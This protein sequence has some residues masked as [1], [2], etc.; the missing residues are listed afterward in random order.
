[1]ASLLPET[2]GRGRSRFSKALP[3]APREDSPERLIKPQYSP[4]PP[5]PKDAMPAPITIPRRPVGS[6]V[7]E[8]LGRPKAPSV[9]TT[10]SSVYSASTGL[11]E[12]S[13]TSSDERDSLSGVDSEETGPPP[14]LPKKDVQRRGLAG[15]PK[16]PPQT[17]VLAQPSSGY[18]CAPTVTELWKRRSGKSDRSIQFPD[19][20]LD[21]SNGSTAVSP[22]KQQEQ[23][24]RSLQSIPFKLPRS[25]ASLRRHVPAR[26]APPQPPTDSILM[27][28]KITKLK[29]KHSRGKPDEFVTEE[30]VAMGRPDGQIQIQNG[31]IRP[32]RLATPEY[33]DDEKKAVSTPTTPPYTPPEEPA[34]ELP[35]RSDS[36]PTMNGTNSRPSTQD[37]ASQLSI[38]RRDITPTLLPSVSV[39]S[40]E[41]PVTDYLTSTPSHSRDTSETLTIT[42]TPITKSSPQ[43]S[44]SSSTVRVST[45]Q[46]PPSAKPQS[47]TSPKSVLSPTKINFPTYP[48]P[49]VLAGAVS[50]GPPISTVQL[51]CYQSHRFMRS[52][53]NTLCPV[54]C[55]VCQRRDADQ[56]WRCSW[57]CLSACSSCMGILA[58]VPGK[59]LRVVLDRVGKGVRA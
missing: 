32:A 46:S 8:K 53:R 24:E 59:D 29:E 54:A 4:L 15:S 5:L 36:R 48:A 3:S 45:P 14:P 30:V 27:G 9:S 2:P 1:M 26:P 25:T 18:T 37:T 41:D 22:P 13:D 33:L 19:L 11:S 17:H 39:A 42:T 10:I 34:P 16:T 58:S 47:P 43:P 44:Q 7:S 52:T 31:N 56:R 12:G 50:Q 28:A 49:A 57:C 35:K 55:M 6:G 20:K 51:N 21:R 23:S 40:S 38:Q